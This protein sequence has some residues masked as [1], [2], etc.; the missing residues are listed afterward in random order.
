MMSDEI[1]EL[2][3][4]TP[5]SATPSPTTTTTYESYD[6]SSLWVL[7]FVIIII[8]LF[9]LFGYFYMLYYYNTYSLGDAIDKAIAQYN[10]STAELRADQWEAE[11]NA[12]TGDTGSNNDYI[13]TTTDLQDVLSKVLN[14]AIDKHELNDDK[15]GFTDGIYSNTQ[16]LGQLNWSLIDET[17]SGIVMDNTNYCM[18]DDIFPTRDVC[19]N[20]KIRTM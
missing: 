11:Y 10:K 17:D 12:R 3:T 13:Q 1:S 4:V 15:E 8:G 6:F 19:I 9:V 5:V 18:S 2:P 20:P 16:Q 7:L 14:D